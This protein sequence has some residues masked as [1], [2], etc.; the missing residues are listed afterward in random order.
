MST[1]FSVVFCIIGLIVVADIVI[2]GVSKVKYEKAYNE[3]LENLGFNPYDL[4]DRDYLVVCKSAKA[5]N[6]YTPTKFFTEHPEVL[7]SALGRIELNRAALNKI[8]VL[9][10]NDSITN[11]RLRRNMSD[12]VGRFQP[13]ISTYRVYLYY[14]SP[15]GKSTAGRMLYIPEQVIRTFQND[16]SLY[17]SKAEYN[18]LS[19]GLQKEALEN[20]QHQ[21]YDR[22]NA[23]IDSVNNHK[24]MLIIR[25]N[26]DVLDEN[27]QKLYGGTLLTISKIKTADSF[28]WELLDKLVSEIET[29]VKAII[30]ENDELLQYYD[31]PE[32]VQIKNTVDG[33]MSS[34]KDFNAYID[35]KV[36]S[37]SS[38][39]GTRVIRNET[40]VE[41]VYDYVRPYKKTITPFVAEVSDAV[42]ASAEN[43]PLEY[44][45]KYFYPNKDVY[46]TQIQ[47]LQVLLQELETLKDAKEIIENYKKEYSDYIQNV[48]DFVME[49]DRDGFY[50]RLGFARIDENAL[51][52]EYKFSY[53]SNGGKARRSFSVPMTEETIVALIEKLESK[54][55][56]TAFAKEQ[57]ALMTAKLRQ[58]ILCRDNHT[59]C[60]C[61]NSTQN[62][63]NLLLEV[64]H[65]IPVAKGGI[66]KEDNLQ[67]LCWR[68]NRSK[69][70]KLIE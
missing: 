50:A 16:P 19:K 57:R 38:L 46:P 66:T 52:V 53:T 8:D 5:V 32:F 15:A 37:I 58:S 56:F 44:V 25:K 21:F 55:T 29:N 9:L 64:D 42:F 14:S 3:L 26:E 13:H 11:A 12:I 1:E 35:E 63:P 41:D 70:K 61:G 43:S 49:K 39:F 59:C 20:K 68:C 17:M 47:K 10:S 40:A 18:K 30:D 36:Q 28:D 48:P 67:T 33:L 54:L 22:I 31:S 24:G 69:G 27:I 2:V 6:S 65:V 34:Q 62:E 23:I 51:T 7:D 60:F 4:Q 45:V